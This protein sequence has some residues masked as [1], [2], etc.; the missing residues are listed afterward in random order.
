MAVVW[1]YPA[2]G[3]FKC[4]TNCC[5]KEIYGKGALALLCEEW[6]SMGGDT[7]IVASIAH[8]VSDQFLDL[9]LPFQ[10]LR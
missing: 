8:L 6:G 10:S 3:S 5:S 4:N 1:N 9:L 7:D 2:L